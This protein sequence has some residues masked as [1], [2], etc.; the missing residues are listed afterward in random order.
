MSYAMFLEEYNAEQEA[1]SVSFTEMSE[2]LNSLIEFATSDITLDF[3]IN[4]E[5]VS[6]PVALKE[7]ADEAKKNA[8]VKFK[9]VLVNWATKAIEWVK[10]V[11]KKAALAV[12]NSGNAAIK[13]LLSEKATLKKDVTL[14]VSTF[15]G[16]QVMAIVNEIKSEMNTITGFSAQSA[17]LDAIVDIKKKVE[18]SLADIKAKKATFESVTQKAGSKIVDLHKLYVDPYIKAVNYKEITEIVDKAADK[19]KKIAES[20]GKDANFKTG[21]PLKPHE[22]KNMREIGT[23][24]MQLGSVL[25]SFAFENLST[26]VANSVKLALACGVRPTEKKE[27][28]EE[29]I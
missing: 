15:N 12:A 9:E 3:S 7:A 23:T 5:S 19:A 25:M 2:S 21:E 18:G 17:N 4:L 13:K 1:A 10:K 6:D 11:A 20:L 26:G 24:V 27:E 8:L 16:K 29:S 14:K 22:T 28:E